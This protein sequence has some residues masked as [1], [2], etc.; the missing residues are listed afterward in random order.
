MKLIFEKGAPGQHLT[1]MPP[2]DVPEVSLANPRTDPL[3][4]PHVSETELTR[5]YTALAK[6]VHGV[7]DGFYPL[8][9]CT[10]KYNP[11]INEDMAALPGFS[12]IH[13]HQPEETVQGCL[14]ALHESE[15]LLCEITGMD[16]M[17][18]Q[19]AAG[20]HGEFTGLLLIKAYHAHRGD[21]ARTKII[22]PDSAHGTNPA[23]AVMAGFSVVNIPSGEDGCVDVEAL[24]AAVGPDTAGLMLTNPNTVGIFDKNILEITKTVHEAG[25]LCYYDGANL[26][27]VMGVVRPGDMGFD[28]IHLNLHKTFSTPHGGGGPGSGAVGCKEFLRCFLPGPVV[29]KDDSGYHFVKPEHS[30]GRV[31][32]FYGNFLVVIRALTYIL[33]LG[34]EGIPEAAKNAVLNANYMMKRLSEKYAMAYSGP[35]MHE[36]VMTLQDLKD[37]TG[38]SY[39]RTPPLIKR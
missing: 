3:G 33:T 27:A 25:G 28:V 31:K 34:R 26:N 1:L 19:P 13:P 5:H 24:R 30:I 11:K 15:K 29:A 35:C 32:D 20:A 10:M 6:R 7:N 37:A 36:F 12:Q 23:S 39:P 2:C 17:T 14:E 8:G 18:F 4:L 21:G 9:S 16:G 38:C 22:V